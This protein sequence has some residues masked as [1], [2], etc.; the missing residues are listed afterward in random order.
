MCEHVKE[1]RNSTTMLDH[2]EKC[3]AS[4]E[5]CCKMLNVLIMPIYETGDKQS[6]FALDLAWPSSSQRALLTV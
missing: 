6:V 4:R 1:S 5:R 2:F 3:T